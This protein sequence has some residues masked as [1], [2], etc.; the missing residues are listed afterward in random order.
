MIA[1]RLGILCL[2]VPVLGGPVFADA[3]LSVSAIAGAQSCS[4][5]SSSS[6]SC[7]VNSSVYVPAGQ[8]Y[9]PVSA[10]GSLSFAPTD[11]AAPSLGP[12]TIGPLDYS[13]QGNWSMGQGIGLSGQAQV[14]LSATINLPSDSGNWTFYGT[15]YD[16]TDDQGGGVGS[17]QIVTTDGSGWIS[18]DPLAS[19]TIAH[20]PGTP[21]S[22]LIDVSDSVQASDSTNDFD[23]QLRMVDPIAT[24]E[25]ATWLLVLCALP[26][27]F[28]FRKRRKTV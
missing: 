5:A 20:T 8:F 7:N 9:S 12:Q 6:A 14:T 10:G 21:F 18:D 23:L 19:F 24:P 3:L 4:N 1:M 15:A 26:V 25:P 16:V 11:L 2:L 27:I 22:V 17:I 13:L 28:L